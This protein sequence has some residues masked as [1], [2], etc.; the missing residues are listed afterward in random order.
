MSPERTSPSLKSRERGPNSPGSP[1]ELPAPEGGPD[2]GHGGVGRHRPA[3]DRGP[4]SRGGRT[5]VRIGRYWRTPCALWDRWPR[6]GRYP[7]GKRRPTRATVG[8]TPACP[9]CGSSRRQGVGG[10]QGGVSSA[11]PRDVRPDGPLGPGADTGDFERVRQRGRGDILCRARKGKSPRAY[12]GPIGGL[13]RRRDSRLRSGP[14]GRRPRPTRQ[15]CGRSNGTTDPRPAAR[16]TRP[17]RA[18]SARN[19]RGPRHGQGPPSR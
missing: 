18:S 16:D 13:I 17:G 4:R 14:A 12:R 11:V 3:R 8:S 6:L 5:G 7:F 9:T 19:D 2:P 15:S 1:V 10:S